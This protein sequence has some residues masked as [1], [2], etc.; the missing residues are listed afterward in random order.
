M[1]VKELIEKL[2]KYP[3]EM[4]V[5]VNG[6]ETGFDH[7]KS[8]RIEFIVKATNLAWYDGEFE[9]AG[10]ESESARQAVVL[11]RPSKSD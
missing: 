7:I 8:V 1:K 5:L 2:K 6:Y 3:L 4:D 11:W 10:K 9:R